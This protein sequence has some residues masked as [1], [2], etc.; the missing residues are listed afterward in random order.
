MPATTLTHASFFA[1]LDTPMRGL[2]PLVLASGL[3]ACGGESP[4]PPSPQTNPGLA[5]GGAA[6]I[7]CSS[8][9]NG[10]MSE[11]QVTSTATISPSVKITF[12][13][14][15]D[16]DGYPPVHYESMWARSL[17]DGTYEIEN[18]PFYSYDVAV[19]DVVKA[20]DVDGE[21]FYVERVRESGNSVIRMLIYDRGELDSVRAELRALGCD[22]EG[23]GVLLAVNVPADV[24]YTPIFRFLTEGDRAKRWGFEEA[25]L[26]HDP[27]PAPA[28]R[29]LRPT[30]GRGKAGRT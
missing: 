26:C 18:I 10:N 30:G 20:Q 6:A 29:T 22:L 21:L 3:Y 8:S 23:D 9:M 17:P 2:L 24:P 11:R 19:G 1:T 7:G 16:A 5:S 4:R 13:L 27:Q 15:Q 14:V 12:R 28:K 25:V